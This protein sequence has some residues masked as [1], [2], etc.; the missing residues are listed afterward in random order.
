MDVTMNSILMHSRVPVR[1]QSYCAVFKTP[2]SF[3]IGCR[4]KEVPFKPGP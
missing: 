4:V 1:L 3:K 2:E